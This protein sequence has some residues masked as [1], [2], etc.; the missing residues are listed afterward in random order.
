VA[1]WRSVYNIHLLID[2][3]V[4]LLITSGGP[5]AG[6]VSEPGFGGDTPGT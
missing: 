3:A 5:H 1:P 6:I 2:T 4:D